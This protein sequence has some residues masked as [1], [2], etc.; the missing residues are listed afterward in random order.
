MTHLNIFVV[1]FTVFLL[2]ACG[3]GGGGGG[4]ISA[5]PPLSN[6]SDL[7]GL[8][9]AGVELDQIF[10]SSQTD[11]T[12]TVSLLK[13]TTRVTAT[14]SYP[15]ATM[16]VNGTDVGTGVA[17]G[18]ITLNQGNSTVAVVVTAEDR[19][20]TTTYTINVTR[21]TAASFA[22]RAYIKASNAED[23]EF[24]GS[25][26]ALSGDTLAVSATG[27]DSA[28]TGIDGDQGDNSADAAGAVYVFTR[29]PAGV[30]SQQ[31]YVK[32]SNTDAG[33][34]FGSSVA[35]SGDTLAVSAI[36]EDSAATGIDGDQ[37]D[38]NAPNSG[39]VYVFTRDIAGVWSQQS[40]VKASN[41]ESAENN[42]FF[43]E[44]FGSSVALSGDTLAVGAD[45]ED[46]AATGIDG[47]Q[48]DN[49]ATSAGAVYVFTRD[50][51]GVWSQQAYVKASN[52]DAGDVFGDS[53]A[54]S[55]DTLAVG[56][57]FEDSAATGI[58]GDQGDN[59]A[60]GA[61]AVYLFTRDGAGAWS[62]QSYVKASYVDTDVGDK[63]GSSVALSG[64]T[65]AVGVPSEDS[66]ATGI[67]GDQSDNS[68]GNSGAVYVFTRD[69]AGAWS[70][71]AYVKASNTDWD[72]SF[73]SSVALSG[74]TLAV[75]ANG[76]SSY[77]LWTGAVY[78]FTRDAAGAWSQQAYVR[79]SNAGSMD[80]FGSS[81][82][83]SGD[84]VAA[85][86]PEEGPLSGAVYVFE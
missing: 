46:S 51:A 6:D 76:E 29:D 45:G 40:Y 86:A 36:G 65:L 26:V 74:D 53:V 64:D 32:A 4:A 33:D 48:S 62:Q 13:S 81:V 55:G 35:L 28:A 60:R 58:D 54:L 50:P 31:A 25:S 18:K 84:T 2:S 47:D 11:Y 71:Q 61:G 80:F 52:T 30:W 16:T 44:S 38:N 10:Q 41:A 22:Q 78:L 15:N 67:D 23:F 37:G 59:N 57:S 8:F 73:G 9:L 43:G 1:L 66:A 34:V 85:S 21:E 70:Q 27:E 82:A 79:A 17:S 72:G 42:N 19:A 20:T 5:P 56:A 49:S 83:L 68:A 12:A 24:F 69:A 39:A 7:A 14:V 63:F 75:G 3:G 77:D